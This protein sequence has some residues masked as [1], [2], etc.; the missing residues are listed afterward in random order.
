MPSCHFIRCLETWQG[1]S[2]RLTLR[3]KFCSRGQAELI[4]IIVPPQYRETIPTALESP[5][6]VAGNDLIAFTPFLE[7]AQHHR[8]RAGR[9]GAAAQPRGLSRHLKRRAAT[10]HREQDV[11][12][13]DSREL[14]SAARSFIRILSKATHSLRPPA[15]SI[16]T[17]REDG[18]SQLRI[19]KRADAHDSRDT[20]WSV[21]CER[22]RAS[23][24]Y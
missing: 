12:H 9:Q 14:P 1:A 10:K 19:L 6:T 5:Q 18:K 8:V 3:L 15:R 13:L 16:H 22:I 24:S 4:I 20:V 21:L 2:G 23:V 7:D 17:N 11:G